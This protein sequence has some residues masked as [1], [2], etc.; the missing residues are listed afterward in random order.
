MI[1]DACIPIFF[2][3]DGAANVQNGGLRLCTLYPRTYIFYGGEDVISLFFSDIAK[4]APIKV[5]MCAFIFFASLSRI[6]LYC[7]TL[8]LLQILII[9]LFRMYNMFGSGAAHGI[10]THFIQQSDVHDNGKGCWNQVCYILLCHDA[11]SASSG[12]S[13]YN[14]S[15]SHIF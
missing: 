2:H 9:K 13:A 15:P 5:R 12:S 6:I 1:R 3:F 11:T 4:I 14:Y 8:N 7:I 10:Y